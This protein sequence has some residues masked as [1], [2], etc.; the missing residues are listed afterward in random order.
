MSEVCLLCDLQPLK[1]QW[2]CRGNEW[3]CCHD[4]P[5]LVWSQGKD[6]IKRVINNEQHKHQIDNKQWKQLELLR[7]RCSAIFAMRSSL[8][9][10][11]RQITAMMKKA[12]PLVWKNR[13]ACFQMSFWQHIENIMGHILLEFTAN[14]RS[15]PQRTTPTF[16]PK[17][18]FF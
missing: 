5:Q 18:R 3:A 2:R 10:R 12:A 7:I 4:D 15:K 13:K 1:M 8:S 11:S 16:Y 9:K 6:N 14:T 17:T